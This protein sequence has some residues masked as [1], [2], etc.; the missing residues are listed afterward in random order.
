MTNIHV[1]RMSSQ[2]RPLYH[3]SGDKLLITGI[4]ILLST[5]DIQNVAGHAYT[6]TH[7]HTHTIN[8]LIKFAIDKIVFIKI[9]NKIIKIVL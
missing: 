5:L 3:L 9:S 6:C 4:W 8:I 7:A 1:P 2:H